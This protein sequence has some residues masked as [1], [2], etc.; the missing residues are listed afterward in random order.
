MNG[1][2]IHTISSINNHGLQLVIVVVMISSSSR[3]VVMNGIHP[4]LL[5]L[6]FLLT[7]IIL[8]IPLTHLITLTT[9]EASREVLVT[10]EQ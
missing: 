1:M 3:V 6:P 8:I 10:V 9:M 4:N 5:D 7:T 2:H